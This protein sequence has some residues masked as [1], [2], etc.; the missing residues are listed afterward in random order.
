MV[1]GGETPFRGVLIKGLGVE[2]KHSG[3]CVL[4]LMGGETLQNTGRQFRALWGSPEEVE[5]EAVHFSPS[6]TAVPSLEHCGPH[7]SLITL[8]PF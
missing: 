2:S 8:W 6:P 3:P 5:R 1:L 7:E 4:A